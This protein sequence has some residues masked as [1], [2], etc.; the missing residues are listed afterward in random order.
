MIIKRALLLSVLLLAGCSQSFYGSGRKLLEQGQYE[1][2][3]DAFYK[4]IA[5]NPQNAAAWRELGVTYFR[6]GDL[7]KADDALKQASAITPANITT[8]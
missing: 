1:S 6:M 8:L 3:V 7:I 2:A 5:A 4:E